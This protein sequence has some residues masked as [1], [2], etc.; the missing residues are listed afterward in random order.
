LTFPPTKSK[1][2]RRA[3]LEFGAKMR[4]FGAKSRQKNSQVKQ[5]QQSTPPSPKICI[6]II[7]RLIKNLRQ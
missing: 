1:N 3:T 4:D 2:K 6:D 5:Q 7:P